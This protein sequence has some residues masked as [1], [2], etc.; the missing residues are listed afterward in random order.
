MGDPHAAQ[1]IAVLSYDPTLHGPRDPTGSD[2]SLTFFNLFNPVGARDNVRQGA[3]D[4][5]VLA[6]LLE[7]LRIPAELTGGRGELFFDTQK[8]V[9]LGHSQGSL[10]GAPLAAVE[11]RFKAMVFSGLGAILNI[12]LQERK[13]IVNFA[14][15][16]RSLLAFP[17][18][19]ILDDF[20]PV[21]NL[22][23][24]FIEPAD[25]IGYARSY[26]VDPPQGVR[27]DFLMVE[28]FLDFASPARGQEAF[29]TAAGFPIVAPV[30]RV[31]EA[32]EV[33]G[34]APVLNT[35]RENVSSAAGQVTAGLIQYPNET[36]FPI[37]DNSDAQRRYLEFIVSVINQ[38]RGEISLGE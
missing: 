9:F 8:M 31:P 7:V 34:P 21:L 23:Q 35:A 19:E 18:A 10:V 11:P 24:T 29:A 17:E 13:D 32:M 6:S 3:A 26:L 38:G 2:P 33:L 4:G 5:V 12:T 14:E 37:F 25:P 28:G 22:I 20:H 15:L 27:R 30:H 36:H 16:L 1:G